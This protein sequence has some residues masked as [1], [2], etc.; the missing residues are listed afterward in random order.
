M[1]HAVAQL[2]ETLWYK[3]ES[4]GFDSQLCHWNIFI[5]IIP[6][7]ALWPWGLLSL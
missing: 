7:V 1:G 2:V 4:R 6:P 3:P 5:D